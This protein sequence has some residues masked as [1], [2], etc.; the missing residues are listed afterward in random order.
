MYVRTVIEERQM[1]L[2]RVSSR[3]QV[4]I[5]VEFRRVLGIKPHDLL[6]VESVED[7][8][9]VRRIRNLLD[10]KGFCGKA[11]PMEQEQLMIE[12]SA[13]RHALGLDD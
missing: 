6:V 3:G 5:P 7:T 10:L 12:E 4:T 8:I 11:L 9:V 1:K 2:L 13:A